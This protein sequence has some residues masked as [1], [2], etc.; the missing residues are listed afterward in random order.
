MV[1]VAVWRTM[2]LPQGYVFL[3]MFVVNPE[4]DQWFVIGVPE[5]WAK[6]H[7]PVDYAR[8]VGKTIE[9]ELILVAKK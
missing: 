4:S 1:S 2:K 8:V 6:S 5:P 7:T 9:R 3:G